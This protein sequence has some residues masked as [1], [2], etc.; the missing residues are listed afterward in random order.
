MT[1]PQ[2]VPDL[3]REL[4]DEGDFA[5]EHT[6]ATYADEQGDDAGMEPDEAVPDDV[7]GG[8]DAEGGHRP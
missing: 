5:E 8:M 6:S 1:D 7:G 4:P 3:D 2:R